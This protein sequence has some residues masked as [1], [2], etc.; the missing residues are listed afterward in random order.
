[1]FC[2]V[3]S[4]EWELRIG[5]WINQPLHV[6]LLCCD[7]VVIL[8]AKRHNHQV[9]PDVDHPADPVTVKSGAVDHKP[10][11]DGTARCFEDRAAA[12]APQRGHFVRKQDFSTVASDQIP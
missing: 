3:D 11:F 1:V 6:V 12:A 4:E 10:C 5:N 9:A 8:T 7:D 2:E